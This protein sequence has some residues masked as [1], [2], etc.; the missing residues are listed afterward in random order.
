MG[1]GEDIWDMVKNEYTKLVDAATAAGSSN[2]QKM[3]LK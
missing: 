2:D 1:Y 3:I